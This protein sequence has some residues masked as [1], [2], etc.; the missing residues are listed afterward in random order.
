MHQGNVV[1]PVLHC[2]LWI[3]TLIVFVIQQLHSLIKMDN[4]YLIVGLECKFI[5]ILSANCVVKC[6]MDAFSVVALMEPVNV[7]NV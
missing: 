7:L 3:L 4:V 1:V 5:V 2:I 6:L